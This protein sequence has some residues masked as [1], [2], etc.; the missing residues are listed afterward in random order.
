[1]FSLKDVNYAYLLMLLVVIIAA[2]VVAP[3]VKHWFDKK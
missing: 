1:M 2:I 3:Q